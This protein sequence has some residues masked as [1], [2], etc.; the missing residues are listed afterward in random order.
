MGR[1]GFISRR[2]NKAVFI[3]RTGATADP[4]PALL[5]VQGGFMDILTA[6]VFAAVLATIVS[7]VSGITAMAYDGEVGHQSSA[8]W[9]NW[10]V[11]FQALALLAVVLA[12]FSSG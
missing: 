1:I 11:G 12:I 7:L 2:A 3:G 8:K 6:L 5:T 10:R 9:M 4:L